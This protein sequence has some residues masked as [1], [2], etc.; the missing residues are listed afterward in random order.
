[1]CQSDLLS[2]TPSFHLPSPSPLPL[3]LPVPHIQK[4]LKS[5]QQIQEDLL[6]ANQV[7]LFAKYC[8]V[9]DFQSTFDHNV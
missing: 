1:M 7:Q 2:Q 6:R 4:L 5:N 9:K 8:L 3:F